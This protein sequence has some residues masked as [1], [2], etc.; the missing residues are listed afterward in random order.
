MKTS[1]KPE[2]PRVKI[3]GYPLRIDKE[4]WTAARLKSVKIGKPLS[5]VIAAL[6]KKWA[7]NEIEI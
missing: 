4:I 7:K 3:T 5:K 2:V 6:L 1:K